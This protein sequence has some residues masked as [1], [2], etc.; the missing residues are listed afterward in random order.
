MRVN[1]GSRNKQIAGVCLPGYF[2]A[3]EVIYN[4]TKVGY[5]SDRLTCCKTNDLLAKTKAKNLSLKAKDSK[6]VLEDIS[7][8]GTTTLTLTL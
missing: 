5:K 6:F 2:I 1:P 4:C 7:R 8:P 3:G